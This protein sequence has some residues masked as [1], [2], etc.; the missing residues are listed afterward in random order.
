MKKFI[1]V[2]LLC[3]LFSCSEKEK[4]IYYTYNDTTITRLDKG[5]EIFLYYGRFENKNSLPQSYIKATYSGFD[6]GMNC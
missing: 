6:G 4:L 3:V 5:N 1:S 2:I